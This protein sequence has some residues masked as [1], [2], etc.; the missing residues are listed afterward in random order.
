MFK[1]AFVFFLRNEYYINADVSETNSMLKSA[2]VVGFLDILM[3]FLLLLISVTVL[4]VLPVIFVVFCCCFSIMYY[5]FNFKPMLFICMFYIAMY[6]K[7]LIL[8]L[9][10]KYTNC[11]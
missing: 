8:L 5:Q 10:K 1:C 6:L 2:V 4:L 11:N 3:L 9:K 7:F